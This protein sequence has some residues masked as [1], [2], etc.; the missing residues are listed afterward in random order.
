VLKDLMKKM[1]KQQAIADPTPAELE[2][3]KKSLTDIFADHKLDTT[4]H[5]AF[6]DALIEWKRHL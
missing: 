5:K 2:R 4:K 1:Q 6:F 3:Q